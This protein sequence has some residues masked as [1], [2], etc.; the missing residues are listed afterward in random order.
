MQMKPVNHKWFTTDIQISKNK[1]FLFVQIKPETSQKN[2]NRS[3]IFQGKKLN[4][5][6]HP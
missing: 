1:I 6:V 5:D 3:R 4:E 2:N